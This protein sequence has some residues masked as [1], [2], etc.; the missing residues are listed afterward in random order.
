MTAVLQFVADSSDPWGLVARYV[1]A[2]VPGSYLALSHITGDKL[3]AHSVQT[4][5]EIYAT[6][7][8]GAYPRPRAEIARFFAGLELVPPYA[9][10]SRTWPMSASGLNT[11]RPPTATVRRRSTAASRASPERGEHRGL[12]VLGLDRRQH[13]EGPTRS[14][15]HAG[16]RGVRRQRQHDS[17]LPRA[18]GR[19]A[20]RRAG[21]ILP[22]PPGSLD[23]VCAW[24]AV[25]LT[26]AGTDD[27]LRATLAPLT[28]RGRVV[29]VDD[30]SLILP[31]VLPYRR[32]RD[33][34][35]NRLDP[36]PAA[37]KGKARGRAAGAICSVTREA[38][39]GS[40]GRRSGRC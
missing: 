22:V 13:D 23:A 16:R 40:C 2:V 29:V 38:A 21:Q 3:S 18:R 19:R 20:G 39:T 34:L 1:Q 8:E 9:A 27:F 7:T 37:G 5:V 35:R 14:R 24:V 17:G 6:A 12:L 32:H 33:H 30:A 10:R 15:R 26:A 11:P 4:G 36:R 25:V 31:A 28:A